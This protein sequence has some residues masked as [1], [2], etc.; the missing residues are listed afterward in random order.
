MYTPNDITEIHYLPYIVSVRSH[1]C[2]YPGCGARYV[3]KGALKDHI[4]L[5]Q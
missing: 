3:Q 5:E 4:A 1:W 2:E